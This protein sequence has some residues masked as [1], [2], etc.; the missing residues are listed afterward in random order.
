MSPFKSS[1]YFRSLELPDPPAA[2]KLRRSAS[3]MI[4]QPG[5]AKKVLIDQVVDDVTSLEDASTFVVFINGFVG[6][7]S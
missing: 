7:A 1:Q 2:K 6:Y 5:D 4:E 3:V